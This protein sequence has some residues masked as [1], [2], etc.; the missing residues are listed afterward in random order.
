MA[1]L[2]GPRSDGAD[3]TGDAHELRSMSYHQMQPLSAL[4]LAADAV[5]LGATLP[6]RRS[7]DAQAMELLGTAT[8]MLAVCLRLVAPARPPTVGDPAEWLRTAQEIFEAGGWP[9]RRARSLSCADSCRVDARS[10]RAPVIGWQRRH[11]ASEREVLGLVRGL[12]NRSIAARL[13]LSPRTVEK[14][15]QRLMAKTGTANRLSWPPTR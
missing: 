7:H 11:H 15:V 2:L 8:F 10:R 5:A 14:H 4:L 12:P 3:R 6:R 1:V 9:N 13:Y